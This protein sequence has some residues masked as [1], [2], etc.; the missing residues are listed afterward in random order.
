MQVLK[1]SKEF[2]DKLAKDPKIQKTLLI[3]G[4]KNKEDFMRLVIKKLNTEYN[5]LNIASYATFEEELN[6]E[7]HMYNGYIEGVVPGFKEVIISFTTMKDGKSGNVFLNQQVMPMI[8]SKQEKDESFLSNSDIKKICL[9]TTQISTKNSPKDNKIRFKND[10]TLQMTLNLMRTIGFDLVDVF[11]IENTNLNQPYQTTEELINHINLVQ[12]L[13]NFNSQ[14]EQIKY[15]SEKN[16]YEVSFD[17]SKTPEGQ[18]MKFLALKIF[19]LCKLTNGEQINLTKALKQT[20]D[21]SLVICEKYALYLNKNKVVSQPF[22]APKPVTVITNNEEVDID[23]DI[24]TSVEEHKRSP[25]FKFNKSGKKTATRN[26]KIINKSLEKYQYNC[27]LDD[28]SHKSIYFKSGKNNQN[29]L[30]GHHLIPIEQQEAYW[31]DFKVNLDCLLNV[32]PLCPICHSKV[33]YGNKY[34]KLEVLK[35]LYDK[36]L[37]NLKIIDQEITFDKLLSFYN[38][39]VL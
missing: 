5:F 4:L 28:E 2:N 21:R 26:A 22:V 23:E 36:C 17:P 31:H 6:S 8:L 7:Y 25:I 24:D 32:E 20:T 14:H 37:P 35:K 3:Y 16:T 13:K 1:I 11:R 34:V 33:H 10:N 19:A 18:T 38:V 30:E 39:Y 29:F 15:N 12:G 9:L 27:A